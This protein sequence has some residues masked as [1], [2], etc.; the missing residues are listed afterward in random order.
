MHGLEAHASENAGAFHNARQAFF[1]I[2]E[3]GC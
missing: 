2:T 1:R 3:N